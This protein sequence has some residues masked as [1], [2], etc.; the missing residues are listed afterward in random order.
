MKSRRQGFVLIT[1]LLVM[2]VVALLV[3]GTAFT[4]L[5]NRGITANQQGS[6]DAYYVAKAGAEKYK[7]VAFQTYRYYLEHPDKYQTALAKSGS[8]KENYSA[9][10]NFLRIG[11]DLNRDG[12]FDDAGDLKD[13]K[14]LGP[15]NEG[16]GNYTIEFELEKS[17]RYVILTSVGRVGR[18]RS[19]VQLVLEARNVS[20]TSNALFIG[21]GGIS[22]SVDVYG[23]VYIKKA[24]SPSSTTPLTGVVAGKTSS[25]AIHN[26]YR[27]QTLTELLQNNNDGVVK[28]IKFLRDNF[29][30]QG[31]LCS[32]LRAENADEKLGDTVSLGAASADA[33][34]ENN[35]SG[36]RVGE[37]YPGDAKLSGSTEVYADLKTK[38]DV[39]I[40]FP[41]D[42]GTVAVGAPKFESSADCDPAISQNQDLVFEVGTVVFGVL[43]PPKKVICK[44]VDSSGATVGFEYTPPTASKPGV[45]VVIGLVN[46][47]GLNLNFEEDINIQID[48]EA[49]LFV[50]GDVIIAKNLAFGKKEDLPSGHSFPYTNNVLGV[51]ATG[52][53]NVSG[54]P[55]KQVMVGVFHAGE[56]VEIAEGTTVFGSVITPKLCVTSASVSPTDPCDGTQSANFVK[57]P[58]LEY[59]LPPGFNQLANA[60]VPTFRVASFERR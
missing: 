53:I 23:S 16:N 37:N 42:L 10:G 30:K 45:L 5:V 59:N 7:T 26:A 20:P 17:G 32:S 18:S 50:E 60:T 13:G 47:Q 39:E 57:I 58:D 35:L 36:V 12:D 27:K 11:L 51:I 21:D 33:D 28:D 3:V 48:G 29:H 19:T 34:L 56:R 4:T 24:G 49:T 31:N 9:C 2:V 40:N 38:L 46:F 54:E 43:S 1:V 22:G 6:T 25:F 44:S 55:N 15:F 41:T 8:E 52:K 14:T